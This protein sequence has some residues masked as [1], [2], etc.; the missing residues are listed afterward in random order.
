MISKKFNRVNFNLSDRDRI[1]NA[2]IKKLNLKNKFEL[3]D[4][5]EGVMFLDKHIR[6]VFSS[7]VVEKEYNI[8]LTS[9]E[10]P[11]RCSDEFI[12]NNLKHK[13]VS[14]NSNG[15]IIINWNDFEVLIIV[16]IDD[17]YKSG[18][19]RKILTKDLIINKINH[20]RGKKMTLS[21]DSL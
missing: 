15:S 6:R 18:F 2:V 14:P 21:I 5:M 3:N 20:K 12:H 17:V 7:I 19:I 16:V 11:L 13:I 1:V 8:C 10:K 9:K 4:R